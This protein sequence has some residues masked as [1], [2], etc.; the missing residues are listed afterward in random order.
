MEKEISSWYEKTKLGESCDFHTHCPDCETNGN[1]EH[2]DTMDGR[3]IEAVN[4]YAS[5]CDGCGEQTSHVEMLMDTQ[6]QLGYCPKCVSEMSEEDR[7]KLMEENSSL[8]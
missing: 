5:T 6:T 4:E 3:C 8:D 7:I 2:C 1:C